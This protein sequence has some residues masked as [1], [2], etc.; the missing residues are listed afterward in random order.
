VGLIMPLENPFKKL[1]KPQIYAVIGGTVLLGGAFEYQHH[2]STGSWSPFSKAATAT[3]SAIDPV[4]N[5]PTSEDDSIDPI[6]NLP[7]LAE[8][9][10]YGSVSAAEASVSAFGAS[11]QT[12]SGIGVSPASPGAGTTN[13]APGAVATNNYTSSAA[14]AQAVQTG[15][16]RFPE[17]LLTTVPISGPP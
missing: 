4:T 9:Q 16:S 6:T 13:I 7:Y 8:A 2:K 10:Q 5:L 11:S 12:G 14:W 15:L 3:G 17:T 1:S